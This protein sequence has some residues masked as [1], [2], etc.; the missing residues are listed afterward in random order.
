[1]PCVVASVGGAVYHC[2]ALSLVATTLV[3]KEQT[4]LRMF[5][6]WLA[7][8]SRSS[9]CSYSRDVAV[10]PIGPCN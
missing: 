4:A 5:C 6:S 3:V 2:S 10:Y 8:M 7:M 9:H 1:M